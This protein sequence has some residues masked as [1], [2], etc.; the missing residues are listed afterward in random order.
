MKKLF[1][2]AVITLLISCEQN[3]PSK[4][5]NETLGTKKITLEDIW[6]ATFS[7]NRMNAL[8]SMN[9][10]YYSLLNNYENGYPTVDKYSYTSLE[11]VATIVDGK[12][13]QNLQ[14]FESYSF[15]Q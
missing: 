4:N 11:K 13:L 10:D 14:N 5:S 1:I 15:L 9:G 6:G 3:N 7:T 12:T 8:N 2:L